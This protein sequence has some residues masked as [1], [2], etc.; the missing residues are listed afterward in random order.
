MELDHISYV[1]PDLDPADPVLSGLPRVLAR[2][3]EQ[4]NGFVQFD[5]GLH[6][7]GVCESPTWHSLSAVMFGPKALHLRYPGL[8]ATDIPFAQDCLTDQFLLR[9]GVVWKLWA[10][11]GELE[12]LNLGPLEFLAQAGTDPVGFLQM[13]PLLQFLRGGDRLA[14]GQ[15]LHVYPPFSTRESKNGVSIKAVP[16]EEALDFLADFARQVAQIPD[17]SPF[18]VRVTP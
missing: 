16:C 5:G 10:E 14:P 7:R 18:Q 15:V 13:Q 11:T 1:G 2:L 4:V 12:S 8:S 3:L 9:D 6:V 17:G